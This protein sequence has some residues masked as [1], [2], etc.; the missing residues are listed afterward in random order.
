MSGLSLTAYDDRPPQPGLTVTR[1]SLLVLAFAA[2]G[3]GIVWMT[4]MRGGVCFGDEYQ[5][6]VMMTPLLAKTLGYI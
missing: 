6:L 1:A 3:L 5:L 4:M 2:V